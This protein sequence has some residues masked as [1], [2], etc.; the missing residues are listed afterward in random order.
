[1]PNT[2]NITEATKEIREGRLSPVDLVQ[3]CLRRIDALEE[4]VR[5]WVTVDREGAEAQARHLEEELAHGRWYGPLHGIPVGIKDIMYTKGLRTSAGSKFLADFVPDYDAT[6]VARLRSAGAI[7]L[8]KTVTTEF[9]CFDPAETR[10]P[11][12]LA[13]TPGGSS[14]GSAAAVASR[15]CPAALGSQTGGSISRPAAYCGITGIKPTHGRVSVYGVLPVSFHLDHVGPLCRSVADGAILLEA[16]AGADSK[17]P[18]CS[19]A[20]ETY[21]G[22]SL[23]K[24][25]EHPPR[26]G[27]V[28]PYFGQKA[29][30]VIREAINK[31][32][33]LFGEGGAKVSEV[34]LP[35][36]FG[37]VH[38]MHK[39]IMSTD[40]ADVH[41]KR[42]HQ[43]ADGFGP[44]IRAMIQEGLQI[45]GVAYAEALRH[46]LK[47]RREIRSVFS[48]VD[49]LL[50][51]ATPAPAP[52][53]LE[54]TGDPSFNSP[55]S[56]CGHPTVVLPV[57][58]SDQGL[59]AAVQLTGRPYDEAGLLAASRWCEQLLGWQSSPELF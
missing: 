27:L 33:S 7:I 34:G 25:A 5:A 13:H 1:M 58:E 8:G 21:F 11:W 54:S 15:M 45:S 3:A 42:F 44:S 52:E 9:A 22:A 20:P 10:N 37:E 30:A 36:S 17:D 26:I 28:R 48:D 50:T 32:V 12:N 53:G 35:D 46:Q 49:C 39:V 56:Y 57:S 59:P 47:F 2:L 40:A 18:F 31:A 6:V 51:P 14:S 41:A 43:A 4:R 19:D 38:R 16:I 29:D 23:E 55:W 24:G